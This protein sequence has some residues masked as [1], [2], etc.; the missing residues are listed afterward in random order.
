MNELIA[1]KISLT[2]NALDLADSSRMIASHKSSVIR[3]R[4]YREEE[5]EKG[6]RQ[7]AISDDEHK[8]QDAD[9]DEIYTCHTTAKEAFKR[10][11]GKRQSHQMFEVCERSKE[12]QNKVESFLGNNNQS[13]MHIDICTKSLR[14][15]AP[16][17]KKHSFVI[18]KLPDNKVRIVTSWAKKYC[19]DEWD[20]QK[21]TKR[22][23]EQ[24]TPEDVADSFFIRSA[25]KHFGGKD[26]ISQRQFKN[27]THIL[28]QSLDAQSFSKGCNPS[29][30]NENLQTTLG[31]PLRDLSPSRTISFVVKTG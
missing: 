30:I 22:V 4:P 26:G 3:K 19:A 24:E 7:N 12:F 21:F 20:E 17:N 31:V 10:I 1:T 28:S 16:F 25:M 13:A 5:F 14:G 18:E 15:R 11:T 27:F 2:L 6:Y 29:E 8:M 9:G 23:I